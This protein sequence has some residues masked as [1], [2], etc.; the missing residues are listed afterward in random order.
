[1]NIPTTKSNIQLDL[2]HPKFVTRLE[3]FFSD[4]RIKGKVKVN[5]GCRS[6]ATQMGYYKAYKAG[7]GNLAAN[8]DRRF[9]VKGLDGQGIWRGSWHMEQLDGYCYAV[10]LAQ[11][12]KKLSKPDIN[13]IAVEYGIVPTIKDKEWW[14]HQPRS[15]VDWFPAPALTGEPSEK[16]D[17]PEPVT[18]WAGILAAIEMQR[19]EVTA[20]PLRKGAKGASVKT[21]QSCLGRLGFE[22][23]IADGLYGRKTV[24]AVKQFQKKRG[25][26]VT[27]TV[28]GNTFSALF[29]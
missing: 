12:S 24:W 16:V 28:D 13:G 21:V 5:S 1:M 4:S 7:K 19:K 17:A 20:F 14:H 25:L 8:P 9:G 3:A 15:G 23:G 29:K 11:W 10:D 2:L 22:C 27:G 6:Y 18:D 26:R